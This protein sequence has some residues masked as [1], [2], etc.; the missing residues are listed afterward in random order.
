MHHR[1]QRTWAERVFITVNG[2]EHSVASM[3]D[4]EPLWLRGVLALTR[5]VSTKPF[6]ALFEFTRAD[7]HETLEAD[8]R[9]E[10]LFDSVPRL[11]PES[12][13]AA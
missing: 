11:T 3:W 6:G 8:C 10:T 4:G 12:A 5:A 13:A 1:G 2:R 9:P 7:G